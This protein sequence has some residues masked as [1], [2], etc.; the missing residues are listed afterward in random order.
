MTAFVRTQPDAVW[1]AGYDPAR[2]DL[3]D[4]DRK[5]ASGINGNDGGTYAPTTP[6]R[7]QNNVSGAATDITG[8]VKVCYGARFTTTSGGRFAISGAKFE[9]LAP[10][11]A[12]SARAILTAM[13]GAATS[14]PDLAVPDPLR[15]AVRIAGARVNVD[16]SIVPAALPYLWTYQP[17][18]LETARTT[19]VFRTHDGATL[20][21]VTLTYAQAGGIPRARVVRCT[22]G[23]GLLP[24]SLAAGDLYGWI[25]LPAADPFQAVQTATLAVDAGTV[26]DKSLYFYAI[27]IEEQPAAASD[28]VP[29]LKRAV[30]A[31]STTNLTVYTGTPVIDGVQTADGDIIL[32][33]GQAN[34]AENGLWYTVAGAHL[35]PAYATFNVGYDLSTSPG[36]LPAGYVVP[37]AEGQLFA[38]S[39]WRMT[40]RSDV[41]GAL[42]TINVQA[43][44][45]TQ[46]FERIA[47]AGNTYFSVLAR[48]TGITDTRWQ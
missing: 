1:L 17:P 23:G 24:V 31:V 16:G 10:G 41:L 15:N 46:H 5:V 14:I 26:I 38:G 29:F 27:Q 18:T 37:V 8:P 3:E 40:N 33:T 36:M 44:A 22:G 43:L 30:R 11:H 2:A 12:G 47:S 13:A 39:L 45:V 6:I 35:Y 25:T 4:F 7:F 28:A 9:Q 42:G 34:P 20:A 19:R 21:S 48:H 32:L